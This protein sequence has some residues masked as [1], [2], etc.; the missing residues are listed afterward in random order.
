MK[1]QLR[2]FSDNFQALAE[3]NLSIESIFSPSKFVPRFVQQEQVNNKYVL[4][5]RHLSKAIID[6]RGSEIDRIYKSL[7]FTWLLKTQTKM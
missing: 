4:R 6:Y 5:L 1:H 2:N 7:E 3:T